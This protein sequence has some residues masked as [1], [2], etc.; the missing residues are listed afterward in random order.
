MLPSSLESD[1]DLRSALL[2]K[3]PQLGKLKV[4]SFERVKNSYSDKSIKREEEHTS[5]GA[6]RDINITKTE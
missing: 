3:Q 1:K 2:I 4:T 6:L 5:D